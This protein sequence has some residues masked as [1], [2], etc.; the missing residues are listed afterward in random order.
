MEK[1]TKNLIIVGLVVTA[2]IILYSKYGPTKP[3]SGIDA[4]ATL[5]TPEAQQVRKSCMESAKAT[6]KDKKPS[7]E[8]VDKY[9]DECV[10]AK[11]EENQV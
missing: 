3:S 4:D 10:A 2:G 7:Q 11:L 1:G 8:V 9:I 6:F 5:I